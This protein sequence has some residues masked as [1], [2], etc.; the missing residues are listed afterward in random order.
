MNFK[1]KIKDLKPYD[2]N[3]NVF[4]VYSYNGLSMQELLC[5]FFHKIN[6]CIKISNDTIDL[7]SWLVNEGLSMEVVNKLMLWLE[8]GTL[9]NIINVNLFNSLNTKIDNLNSQLEQKVNKLI[10]CSELGMDVKD[11]NNNNFSILCEAISNDYSIFVDND[12][13]I[14]VDKAVNLTNDLIIKSELNTLNFIGDS[15]VV[16]TIN[17]DI[18]TISITQTKITCNNKVFFY[19]D[20]LQNEISYIEIKNN[21]FSDNIVLFKLNEN[22]G[23]FKS[24]INEFIFFN[25]ILES[26][27]M[28]RIENITT[29]GFINIINVPFKKVELTNNTIKNSKV[30][31]FYFTVDED[32]SYRD[33]LLL[34]IS[35][36]LEKRKYIRCENNIFKNNDNFFNDRKYNTSLNMYY[37]LLVAECD[38]LDF[39]YN[40]VENVIA[41]NTTDTSD[42]YISTSFL[43]SC[44][45]NSNVY[46]NEIKN[47]YNGNVNAANYI[48]KSKASKNI[49]YKDNIFNY[50]LCDNNLMFI[51]CSSNE[52]R[53]KWV[54][55][56]NTFL[57]NSLAF[58]QEQI[59]AEILEVTHNTINAQ[60]IKGGLAIGTR[61]NY[62][63]NV[64]RKYIFSNNNIK[65]NVNI[66]Q[67]YEVL[68]F[69][70]IAS[71][72]NKIKG[73]YLYFENN[74]IDVPNLFNGTP[75]GTLSTAGWYAPRFEVFRFK[76]N[77]LTRKPIL[78]YNQSS[79]IYDGNTYLESDNENLKLACSS[80]YGNSSVK[81][82]LNVHT[83][84]IT[85][86]IGDLNGIER[87]SDYLK[88]THGQLITFYVKIKTLD[89]LEYTNKLTILQ[90]LRNNFLY[91]YNNNMKTDISNFEETIFKLDIK[92]P[93]NPIAF[94]V[95][96]ST[97][98][99]VQ[100]IVDSS[101]L[102]K[103]ITNIELS[104]N[105]NHIPL[106]QIVAIS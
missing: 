6:D 33:E 46:N 94:K 64:K 49:S 20:D 101:S 50:E 96:K 89:N 1:D 4:D 82:V 81:D 47:V 42:N 55:K 35:N 37:G 40:K 95:V 84:K 100:A 22:V 103:Y 83:Q 65:S 58:E 9:E 87:N 61:P 74:Y 41:K 91:D 43:Y 99:Y 71:D 39:C 62:N 52:A 38:I 21:Y 73:S 80:L 31:P 44:S 3:C 29:R 72:Y 92:T 106:N 32:N 51:D 19:N 16:F 13:N 10:S 48:I 78:N 28:E 85:M 97:Y 88:D 12:Y 104:Y 36:L 14:K 15:P 2:L 66:D 8:D 57:L 53:G 18:D 67:S 98:S 24:K 102:G 56:D 75:I 77:T 5:Q 25:N 26:I 79:F 63:D 34:P 23:T 86:N 60:S 70:Y 7:A 76:N 27:D 17:S 59:S 11:S 93:N 45:L 90:D 69:Q 54:I 30:L 105:V 68:Y